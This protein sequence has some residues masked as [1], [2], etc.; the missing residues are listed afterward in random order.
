MAYKHGAYG[1]RTAS[2]TRSV[3]AVDENAVY[4]GTAP[5]NLIR[6]YDDSDL[7]NAPV[8][9]K[10]LNDAKAKIG[11]SDAWGK[12]TL[13]EVVDYHFNN[14]VA[15][16]GPI[17]IIN[18]LDPD[19]HRKNAKT[20]QSV[21][22]ANG[23][24]QIVSDTII[25]D[26]IA[27]EDKVEGVDYS[28]EYDFGTKTVIIKSLVENSPITGA[29]DV[30]FWEVDASKVTKATI[31]GG[32]SQAGEYSG[33]AAIAL[34]YMRDNAVANLVAAP[35]WSHDPEVYQALVAGAQQINGHWDAFV[36]ADIPLT[37]NGTA[38]D[39]KEK[40]IQWAE[41]HGYN[42][43]TTKVFWP[44]AKY[45]NKKYHLSTVYIAT[46]LRVDGENDC[47][48]Y[49][50][51]SNK[52]IMATEQYM[53]ESAAA[54]AF[55]QQDANEL[56]AKGITTLIYW[57]GEWILWG[58]HTAAYKYGANVD[59]AAIFETNIRMLM[60]ITNGFQRRH[61]SKIDSPLTPNDKDA[62]LAEEQE[63]L[64]SLQARGALIGEPEVTFTEEENPITNMLN[65]DFMW[66]HIVTVT[67]L[68]KSAT[69]RAT[70]TDEGFQAF[71]GEEG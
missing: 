24:G 71:F 36:A 64:D 27:I 18:V 22:F 31:I 68:L 66:H 11:Y 34:L 8:K 51:A 21:V 60:H 20:T 5:I 33:I 45:N 9:L 56:N 2:K 23:K 6:G 25:L 35:G 17:Y 26:T 69:C 70:Y 38:I 13:A 37:D 19:T 44:M 30:S 55:D 3:V 7:I 43:L 12:F 61:G 41:N 32:K 53:G 10:N 46:A 40:A 58:P 65:G 54:Q 49:D 52:T 14:A 1:E 42:A 59:A 29:T 50:S 39:T 48:P 57:E 16:A 15:N 67:P 28:I 4:I 47:I 62:I 63:E